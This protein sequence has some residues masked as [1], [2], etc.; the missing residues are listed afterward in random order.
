MSSAP[1]PTP[2]DPAP[3]PVPENTLRPLNESRERQID[4]TLMGTNDEVRQAVVGQVFAPDETF[5]RITPEAF[6]DS[7]QEML[8][9]NIPDHLRIGL[10]IL[11]GILASSE[12]VIESI[13]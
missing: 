2:G 12:G 5:N 11:S 4:H 13:D 3:S 8:R 6:E 7:L 1:N 9:G 10:G